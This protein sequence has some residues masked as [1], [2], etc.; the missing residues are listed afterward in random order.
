MT[1]SACQKNGKALSHIVDM[2]TLPINPPTI[3][4]AIKI[5]IIKFGFG[6]QLL[7][8]IRFGDGH[9]HAITHQTTRERLDDIIQIEAPDDFFHL[10]LYR[11]RAHPIALGNAF[12]KQQAPVAGQY[13]ALLILGDV[14]HLGIAIIIAIQ[15][16][17]TQQTHTLGKFAQVDVDDETGRPTDAFTQSGQW[18]HI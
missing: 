12:G 2:R 6:L 13:D 3:V 5:V 8:D 7:Q 10:M 9:Q 4:A 15:A 1:L 17:E 11:N 14:C 18:Q 16:I